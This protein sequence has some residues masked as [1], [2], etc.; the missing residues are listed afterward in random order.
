RLSGV[1]ESDIVLTRSFS[2]RYARGIKNKF[3]EALE[4]A[5]KI[6]PYPYQNKLTGELRRVARIN[7]NADF[8]NIWTGQSI[9]SYSELSTA[10]IIRSL[11]EEVE[12]LHTSLVV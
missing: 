12:I 11:I 2:G 1:N 9:H 10:D 6:L 8:I 7:R 3:I 4:A 5:Q